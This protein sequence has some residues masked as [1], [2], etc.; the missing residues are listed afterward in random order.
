VILLKPYRFNDRVTTKQ[1]IPIFPTG[2]FKGIQEQFDLK[3]DSVNGGVLQMH[4]I[5]LIKEAY[6]EVA[7]H[8][9]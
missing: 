6:E 1:I 9:L 8:G 5:D 2:F 3:I 7:H 4:F